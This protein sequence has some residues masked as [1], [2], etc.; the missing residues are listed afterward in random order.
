[1]YVIIVYD[2]SVERVTKVCHFLRQYLDWVQNSVFE[3]ELTRSEFKKVK[4]G[5][6]NIMNKNSDSIR[7]YKM[8]SEK[9]VKI[10]Q[11]GPEKVDTSRVI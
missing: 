4:D 10:K 2:V 11:L 1:M 9:Y 5:L 3:G 8:S 7:I 6:K